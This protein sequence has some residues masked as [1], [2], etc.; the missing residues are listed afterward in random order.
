V[1][2]SEQTDVPFVRGLPFDNLGEGGNAAAPDIVIRPISWGL[3]DGGE[4]SIRL[5]GFIVGFAPG[6]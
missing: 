2:W 5:S 6:A 3:G 1:S 4:E